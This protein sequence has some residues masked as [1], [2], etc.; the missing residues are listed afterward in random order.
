M[1]AIPPKQS[2]DEASVFVLN[3]QP[4]E[5]TQILRLAFGLALDDRF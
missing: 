2:L 3:M 1:R 5:Q 4:E